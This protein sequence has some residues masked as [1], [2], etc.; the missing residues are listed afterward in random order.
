MT[1]PQMSTERKGPMKVRPSR[2]HT[3]M[4]SEGEILGVYTQMVSE[5][6]CWELHEGLT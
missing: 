6:E 2:N 4:V 5:G 3:Q 1:L